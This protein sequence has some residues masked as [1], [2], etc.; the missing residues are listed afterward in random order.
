M[1]TLSSLKVRVWQD[2][3]ICCTDIYKIASPQ[4][5]INPMV[6]Q[7]VLGR[8][9][10]NRI[11]NKKTAFQKGQWVVVDREKRI[12]FEHLLRLQPLTDHWVDSKTSSW[13]L[14][15]CRISPLQ[16]LKDLYNS[17][18]C[19]WSHIA[20]Y[21]FALLTLFGSVMCSFS[22]RDIHKWPQYLQ[23][24]R[25]WHDSIFLNNTNHKPKSRQKLYCRI[26]YSRSLW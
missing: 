5:V 12:G 14:L 9:D 22:S 17:N 4:K 19:S 6:R 10:L 3:I 24:I 21:H 23:L 15:R 1:S 8:A 13:L 2:K 11:K 20:H 25:L 16:V 26:E 7:R 18:T